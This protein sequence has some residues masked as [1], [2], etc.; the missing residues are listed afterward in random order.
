V[1]QGSGADISDEVVFHRQGPIEVITLNR[2]EAINAFTLNMLRLLA[3]RFDELQQDDDVRAI[4]VTGAGRG[5]CAG[6]D[7]SGEGLRGDA[8]TPVGTRLSVD[9]Y[10]HAVKAMAG[11]EKPVIAAINGVAVGAGCSF[12]LACDFLIACEEARFIMLFV[13]RGLVADT[14]GAFFLPR[15]GGLARAKELFFTGDEVGAGRALELGLVNRVVPRAKLMDEA[16]ELASKLASG[17][18]RAIGMVKRMLNRSFESDL[19]TAL[20]WEAAFRGIAVSS[21][22]SE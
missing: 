3:R 7:L 17:P 6:A 14:G 8:H 18:V 9:V 20:E 16:M 13:H 22:D 12:A 15:L 4:V 19:D 1:P 10:S 11:L 21:E 2:P 5:F